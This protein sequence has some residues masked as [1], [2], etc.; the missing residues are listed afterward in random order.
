[1]RP[2]GDLRQESEKEFLPLRLCM[3]NAIF[4]GGGGGSKLTTQLQIY[5]CN[6]SMTLI[7]IL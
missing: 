2:D 4:F 6:F 7:L 5:K 3:S 1:M